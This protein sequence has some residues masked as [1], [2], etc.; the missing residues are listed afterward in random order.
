MYGERYVGS[1]ASIDS[2]SCSIGSLGSQIE[3]HYNF[4]LPFD[5]IFH[6]ILRV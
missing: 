5:L 2:V 3:Y 4:K 1:H 6:K